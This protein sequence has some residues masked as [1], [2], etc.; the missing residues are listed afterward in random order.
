MDDLPPEYRTMTERLPPGI[1]LI[2]LRAR[3]RGVSFWL[4]RSVR[5]TPMSACMTPAEAVG[6]TTGGTGPYWPSAY[7]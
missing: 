7:T 3:P 6:C 5:E 1:V 4:T 2:E